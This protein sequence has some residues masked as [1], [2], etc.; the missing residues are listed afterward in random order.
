MAVI[1]LKKSQKHEKTAGILVEKSQKR[2]ENC[3]KI[4]IKIVFLFTSIYLFLNRRKLWNLQP[5]GKANGLNF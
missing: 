3:K 5:F 4:P 1:L 2:E